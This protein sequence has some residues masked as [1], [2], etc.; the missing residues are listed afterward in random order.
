MKKITILLAFLIGTIAVNAQ[1]ISDGE[2]MSSVRTKF[3][4]LKLDVDT[5]KNDGSDSLWYKVG[6]HVYMQ[7]ILDSVGIGNQSPTEKLDVTG[8]VKQDTS[9]YAAFHLTDNTTGIVTDGAIQSGGALY[10]GEVVSVAAKTDTGALITKNDNLLYF[11][12]GAGVEHEVAI[13][14][15]N[16]AE[17]SFYESAGSQVIT[18]T[19]QYYAINGEFS[20]SDLQGWTF[21]AGSEGGGNITTADAGASINIADVAHGLVSGDIVNVQSANHEGTATVVYVDDDNFTVVI[22]FVGNEAGTWQEGDYLLA[23]NGT[24]AKYLL[25][26]DFTGSAGAAAKTYKFEAVQNTTHL[27]DSAFEIT[28]SGTANQSS[29]ASGIIT[30]TTGDRIWMQFANETDAE[31]LNFEHGGITLVRL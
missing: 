19:G 31:N 30:V 20:S 12:D 4:T 6:F 1:W 23:S 2:A 7:S 25:I 26:I 21:V 28:T 3:N 5:L 10:F 22:A 18:E 15:R 24:S 14:D 8:N 29:A 9:K 27:D 17:I 16:Y 13:S 11:H